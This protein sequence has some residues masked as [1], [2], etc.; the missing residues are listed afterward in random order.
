MSAN[1]VVTGMEFASKLFDS[2]KNLVNLDDKN[3]RAKNI[4]LNTMFTTSLSDVSKLARVE[5]LTIVSKDCLNL[6]YMPDIMNSLLSIFS[7]YYLTAINILTKV[8][9]VEVVKILDKLNPDRDLSGLVLQ[10]SFESISLEQNNLLLDNYSY[11]LHKTSNISLENENKSQAITAINEVSNLSV[12]KILNIDISIPND[13]PSKNNPNKS[14]TVPITVRLM[15]SLLSTDT[16][17]HILAF[18]NEDE[19]L[20]ERYHA[21]RS[22]RISFIKDLVFCQDLIDEYKKA[23]LKDESCTIQ[24]ILRRVRNSRQYGLLTKNPSLV[25]ASNLFVISADV[26][27]TIEQKLGGKLSNPKIRDKAFENTYAMIIA[28]VDKEW[29]RVTFYTRNYA[30]ATDLSIKEIK[31]SNKSKGPDITDIMKMYNQGI[32]PTF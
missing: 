5:P 30:T 22:G 27:R 8:N 16:I 13:N 6:E 29:E 12:G 24:E 15:A 10:N 26:A 3:D 17:S 18:K 14:V 2:L 1:I 32:S 20:L 25:N 28:V 4:Y 11:S 21:W 31:A 19:S 23:V 9:D 7:G